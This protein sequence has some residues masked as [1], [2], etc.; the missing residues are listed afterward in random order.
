MYFM[1]PLV[2]DPKVSQC[3][4]FISEIANV[5]FQNT[6]ALQLLELRAP[7]SCRKDRKVIQNMDFNDYGVVILDT[8]SREGQG[9]LDRFVTEAPPDSVKLS[10]PSKKELLDSQIFIVISKFDHK[11]EKRRQTTREPA[12]CNSMPKGTSS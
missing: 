2:G 9:T 4:L 10:I 11:K 12:M 7:E 3:V 1:P 8:K 6:P 5:T